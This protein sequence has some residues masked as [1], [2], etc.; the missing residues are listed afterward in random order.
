MAKIR[1]APAKATTNI[2]TSPETSAIGI[3]KLFVSCKNE[4]ITP[5][6]SPALRGESVKAPPIIATRT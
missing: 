5:R 4:A 6:V 3:V 2:L 1:F